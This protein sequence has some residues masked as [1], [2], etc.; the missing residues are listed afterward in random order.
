MLAR[1]KL[2]YEEV[3]GRAI[4]SACFPKPS[5]AWFVVENS[6]DGRPVMVS[7]IRE[8][9]PFLPITLVAGHMS[10]GAGFDVGEILERGAKA[11][12]VASYYAYMAAF[13][14]VQAHAV[15]LQSNDG[16]PVVIH[17]LTAPADPDGE[18][19]F[20]PRILI[21]GD[22]GLVLEPRKTFLRLLKHLDPW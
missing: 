17:T 10:V 1:R 7:L 5:P 11:R 18:R 13:D 15:F 22:R 8:V 14:D 3:V 12:I 19:K 20:V 9:F 6:R 21:P 2:S 16:G 4:V